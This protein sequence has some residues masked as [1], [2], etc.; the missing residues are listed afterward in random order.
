MDWI[1]G[2]GNPSI[3]I[4]LGKELE[5]GMSMMKLMYFIFV[6]QMTRQRSSGLIAH[7]IPHWFAE[8]N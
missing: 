8:E 4:N 2:E 3:E 1:N 7:L 5:F 6:F